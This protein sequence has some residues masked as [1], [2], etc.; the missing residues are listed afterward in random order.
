MSTFKLFL[1]I[2]FKLLFCLA[3]FP[4]LDI[5]KLQPSLRLNYYILSQWDLVN[6][7]IL[8]LWLFFLIWLNWFHS[9]IKPFKPVPSLINKILAPCPP[10]NP[11]GY[12]EGWRRVGVG[13]GGRHWPSSWKITNAYEL[14]SMS[15]PTRKTLSSLT[16]WTWSTKTTFFILKTLNTNL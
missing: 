12:P 5:K 8:L 10:Q 1:P 4:S 16:F 14:D 9:S 7:I 13:V 3:I 2:L 11:Q 15:L 6:I